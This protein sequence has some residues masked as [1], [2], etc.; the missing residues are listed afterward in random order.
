MDYTED[1]LQQLRNSLPHG[2][3]KKL[4]EII[5]KKTDQ[6]YTE[7]SIRRHLQLKYVNDNT[8]NEAVLLAAETREKR[9]A[10]TKKI[11]KKR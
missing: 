5:L 11:I 1:T 3:A 6:D 10:N 7:N 4:R 8:V 2:Y 9:I